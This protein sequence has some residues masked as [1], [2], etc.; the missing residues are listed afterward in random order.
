MS[1]EKIFYIL[2]GLSGAGK[3][4]VTHYLEDQ[5]VYC[6]D[7]LPPELVEK[8]I[9]LTIESS[10]PIGKV[11]LVTDVR[12]GDQ[13]QTIFAALE[14]L[15][16]KGIRRVIIFLEASNDTLVR[17][18]SE[19]RRRHPLESGSLI[20][21]I[22][23]EREVL[24]EMRAQADILVD[25][26]GFSA[27][28]LKKH[29]LQALSRQLPQSHMNL[30]LTSFGFKYGIPVESDLVFDVRFAPNPFYVPELASLTG[31][32]AAVS[33]YVFASEVSTKFMKLLSSLVNFLVPLYVEEGKSHLTISIGCT[34]GQHRSVAVVEKLAE[35]DWP[36][37]VN[38]IRCH[39]DMERNA[40][41]V[42]AAP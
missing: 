28:Q 9:E 19:T 31:C 11:L 17:R 30:V 16:R 5:G 23:R 4:L 22:K 1:D 12:S 33:D 3:S 38:V 42:R 20:D 32:D 36:A 34:G 35:L 7:N 14:S 10:K 18:F 6:V 26:S 39:R 2:T 27:S 13:F 29:I 21:A 24:A 8:F 37:P 25:T 15:K 41:L 40:S